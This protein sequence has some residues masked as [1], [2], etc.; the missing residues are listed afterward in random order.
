VGHGLAA[1]RAKRL[2]LG[3]RERFGRLEVGLGWLP[4]GTLGVGE[5]RGLAEQGAHP[6]E[7]GAG[8][9]VKPA[10]ATDAVEARRQDVLE[11]T[12]DQLE[13]F[14]VQVLFTPRGAVA[15]APAHPAI[16]EQGQVPIAGGGFEDV[17]A[18]ITQG[19]LTGTGG[20]AMDHPTLL[21]DPSGQGLEQVGRIALEALT[22][23]GAVVIG[24]GMDVDEELGTTG[25]PLALNGHGCPCRRGCGGTCVG[26]RCRGLR[27]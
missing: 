17:A 7:L 18:E 11:E 2:G 23:E 19:G 26:H 3:G 15:I 9:G 6:I 13:G 1:L 24:Q 12:A 14:Q 21:P 22:E 27:D 10:E 4:G 5:R 20:L 25:N 8:G 16:G